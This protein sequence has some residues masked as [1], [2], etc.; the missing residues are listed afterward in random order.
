MAATMALRSS[1]VALAVVVVLIGAIF[2]EWAL[3][4][5]A[6]PLTLALSAWF[7]PERPHRDPR[8]VL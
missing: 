1:L 8:E 3:V 6:I 4:W 2:S 7:W 5:G